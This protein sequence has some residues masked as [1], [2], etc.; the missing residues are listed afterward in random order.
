[1]PSVILWFSKTTVVAPRKSERYRQY[2][3][4]SVSDAL[5]TISDQTR[6][7]YRNLRSASILNQWFFF[8]NLFIWFSTICFPILCFF[9]CIFVVHT[10]IFVAEMF[11]LSKME[12]MNI[13]FFYCFQ[14]YTALEKNA[15]LVSTDDSCIDVQGWTLFTETIKLS[16]WSWD[17]KCKRYYKWLN[18]NH[19]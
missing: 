8:L 14:L 11:S 9:Q 13:W 15:H 19:M 18:S 3:L 16:L 12:T 5:E 4:H 10:I 6:R 7:S 2:F 17:W 1:M